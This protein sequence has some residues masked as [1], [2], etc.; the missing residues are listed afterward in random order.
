MEPPETAR[1]ERPSIGAPTA[2]ANAAAMVLSFKSTLRSRQ[3]SRLLTALSKGP[4]PL[5]TRKLEQ[6]AGLVLQYRY[7]R[8]DVIP[9]A[10]V[11]EDRARNVRQDA[12]PSGGHAR[13]H[14]AH[15]CALSTDARCKYEGMR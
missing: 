9:P 10:A 15:R 7:G 13:E 6:L 11:R 2:R 4:W 5:S 3:K 8:P 12:A 1:F 14:V